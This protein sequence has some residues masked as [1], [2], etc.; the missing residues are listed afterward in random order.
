MCVVSF[1]FSSAFAVT[2]TYDFNG[3]QLPNG[4]TS[5]QID[6][7]DPDTVILENPVRTE[8]NVQYIFDGWCEE[9]D[10]ISATNTCAEDLDAVWTVPNDL[11][12][13]T[14]FIAVW[15]PVTQNITWMDGET[16][17]TSG[18]LSEYVPGKRNELLA[19]AKSDFD[20]AGK[21]FI[22]WCLSSDVEDDTTC[23]A[24]NIINVQNDTVTRIIAADLDGGL[25]FYTRYETCADNG[26]GVVPNADSTRCVCQSAGTKWSNSGL[27]VTEPRLYSFGANDN[28][29]VIQIVSSGNDAESGLTVC[30]Y[31]ASTGDY[32]TCTQTVNIC[33]AD[34]MDAFTDLVV[35]ADDDG[36]LAQRNFMGLSD[37]TDFFDENIDYSEIILMTDAILAQD[38]FNSCLFMTCPAGSYLKVV[39]DEPTGVQGTVWPMDNNKYAYCADCGTAHWCPGGTWNGMQGS[40]QGHNECPT[41]STSWDGL[42]YTSASESD[43]ITDC[44][45]NCPSTPNCVA[46]VAN[47][48]GNC[49]YVDNIATVSDTPVKYYGQT[50]ATT[51][52]N[53]VD[54]FG[55][56]S[57]ATWINQ[58]LNALDYGNMCKFTRVGVCTNGC[59]ESDWC[60]T[61]MPGEFFAH[62]DNGPITNVYG[63]ASCNAF[64]SNTP[65]ADR[66][67]APTATGN[68]CWL[69]MTAFDDMEIETSGWVYVQ[70]YSDKATCADSCGNFD[71]TSSENKALMSGLINS[72]SGNNVCK[73]NDITI[74]WGGV[75]NPGDAGMCV[76]GGN[77]TAPT[78]PTVLPDYCSANGCTFLGWVVQTTSGTSGGS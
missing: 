51:F 31:N 62:I 63:I 27:N 21:V 6:S 39:N 14:T 41:A 72:V 20:K 12:T 35:V 77:L 29:C 47:T 78:E 68:H 56:A 48:S 7:A 43:E 16:E 65:V 53:C 75:E 23:A 57:F 30:K 76:F 13:D 10:Y 50:C 26:V 38:S 73:P 15:T 5:Y 37:W 28:A 70:S 25:T 61:L 55:A 54:G 42:D 49:S 44:Y 74:T 33:D 71:Y 60:P 36:I 32:D 9:S 1:G 64:D 22:G 8:G 18:M 59:Q 19:G 69:K 52:T 66:N 4:Q 2:I 67:F 58:N 24:N 46:N 45:T 34:A 40:D 11:T 3:G 17:V